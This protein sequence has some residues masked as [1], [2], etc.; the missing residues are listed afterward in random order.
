MGK[1]NPQL[2]EIEQKKIINISYAFETCSVVLGFPSR[3]MDFEM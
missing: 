2:N 1:I 3:D